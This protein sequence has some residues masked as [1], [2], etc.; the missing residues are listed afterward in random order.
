MSKRAATVAVASAVL[1][2][3]TAPSSAARVPV[4]PRENRA[5]A[6]LPPRPLIAGGSTHTIAGRYFV[7]LR[8][9]PLATEMAAA[10]AQ[11]RRLTAAQQRAATARIAAGQRGALA[12]ARSQGGRIVYRYNRLLDGF[13][14]ELS[15][16]AAARI[17]ARPDVVSVRPVDIVMPEAQSSEHFIGATKVWHRYGVQGRGER[18]AVID[19]GI[20]YTHADFGGPG[21]VR[22]Y[23]RNNPTVIEPHTFPTK[24]VVDGYDFVGEYYDPADNTTENDVPQPDPD[25]LDIDGHGTHTSGICCGE[26]VPHHVPKG[27]APKAKIVSYKVFSANAS[28]GGD[29]I[30]AAIERAVD[31]NQD[32]STED[33]A[34]VISMS[35]GADFGDE[36]SPDAVAAQRAVSL[37][38]VVV[39]AA[40]NASS[41]LTG[42]AAYIAGTPAAAPGAISVAASIVRFSANRLTVTAPAGV[43][44]PDNG[45]AVHQPWSTPIS[46]DL[47][48]SLFDARAVQPPADP[49]GKPA[50]S[51]RE[52]CDSTPAGAPFA[53]K[54]ALVFKGSTSAGD[55]DATEKVFRAQQAGATAVVLWSGFQ[56]APFALA[57]GQDADQIHIPAFLVSSAD[58]AVLGNA[59]SPSAPTSY[60][61]RSVQIAISATATPV[62]GYPDRMADF[63]SEGPARISNILKPDITAP[64]VDIKSAQAG[65]GDKPLVESGTS[66]ATP[67]VSGAAAL[68]LQLHKHWSPAKI[69]AVMMNQA[70]RSLRNNDGSRPV[71]AAI[72]GAG[73]IRAD[74]S[75]RAKSVAFPGSLSFGL[76]IAA[77]VHREVRTFRVHNADDRS[78]TY[79]ATA[80]LHYSD[81][82]HRLA[83]VAL[84][85]PRRDFGQRVAFTLEPHATQAIKARLTLDPRVL[86]VPEQFFG[87]AGFNGDTDGAVKVVQSGGRRDVMNVPW[88]VT[89]E[90]A[91]LNDVTPQLV[92]VRDSPQ[93]LSV[94]NKGA[95]QSF[96][97][98]YLLGAQDELGSRGEEDVTDIGAR[99]FVGPSIDGTARGLPPDS[100]PLFDLPWTQFL[101]QADEPKEPIEFAVRTSGI[102]ST[103]Q[104]MEVDVLI[105]AG[106]DGVF[107]DPQLR[108]DYVLSSLPGN[109]VCLFDLSTP[110]PF[111][112]CAAE[113]FQDYR[114]FN[115]NLIGLPVDVSALGLRDSRPLLSYTAQACTTANDA[116][117]CDGVENFDDTT[118]T[119]AAVLNVTNPPVTVSPLVCGGFFD[120]PACDRITVSKGS[121]GGSDTKLMVLFPDNPPLDDERIVT[122]RS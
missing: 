89:P 34:D 26:G 6:G 92:D 37:G 117:V 110:V 55:C 99:S 39:A 66:Q 49:T 10:R 72:M 52:L 41:Q 15:S 69:K 57:P 53:G 85:L 13:S 56:G 51:D 17:A 107:A 60:N 25:P 21:T 68:L 64:G 67:H 71:S 30:A 44:L 5:E 104:S 8:A 31:P 120:D 114:T 115:T 81:Y 111:S 62:P 83:D 90:A 100:D 33:H 45:L 112:K 75:A 102:H 106:A 16:S 27:V 14:A 103:S 42:G 46:T 7:T 84:A 36:H 32:G 73:R 98:T 24:K 105:D 97:D 11:G 95:G 18:V 40:G 76:A 86:S 93:T 116:A 23:K 87:W 35:L 2:A 122:V 61:T 43:T 91:S 118:G 9:A 79:A 109:V 47:T 78:H 121:A 38:S 22:A 80:N 88:Q 58:G 54:I 28:S 4:P 48:G 12:A 108:A 96:A 74:Q 29:T 1:F 119:W 101:A 70:K 77:H 65:S 63:S 113:Y 50:A 59:L 20:D 19:T 94:T 3:M 82:D